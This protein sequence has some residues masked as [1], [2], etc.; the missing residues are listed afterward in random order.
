MNRVKICFQINF[1]VLVLTG[2]S[3]GSCQ[4]PKQWSGKWFQS[5]VIS[6][7]QINSTY[8]ETKGECYEE[9]GEKVVVYDRSENCYRCMAIHVK[10]PSVLQYK[11]TF[12]EPSSQDICYDISGD[13]PL[14]SMFRKIP[15]A[16]PIPCPFKSA[17]F[18]FQYNKGSEEC[19][20]PPSKAESC[21]DDSRLVL[22]YQACPDVPGT[23]SNVEE[24]ICLAVWKEGSTRYLV[25]KISQWNRRSLNT[26]EDQ[27]RCF[28]Y[29]RV[30][31]RDGE[32]IYN[33]AQSGDASCNGIT[34]ALEGSKTMKLRTVDNHHNRCKF[35]TWITDHHTWLSLDH[36]KT[37][38][39]SQ[40]NAT[41]KIVD[42]DPKLLTP[43]R[44]RHDN[45]A[46]QFAFQTLGFE[47]QEQRKT[48]AEMR[49][50]CH[51]ILQSVEQR[52]VQIVAHITHGCDSGYICMVFHKRDS[53][54]IEIQ[55]SGHETGYEENADDAC[56]NFD[57]INTPYTTLITTTLHP[58]NCPHL[59]RYTLEP[60]PG[61][62]TTEERRKKRQ[63]PSTQST[64]NSNSNS[65]P[66]PNF[67]P[68]QKQSI[69]LDPSLN[70]PQHL[71]P[72]C[73]S[74]DFE[75]LAVGCG[76]SQEVMEFRTPCIQQPIAGFTCHGSWEENNTFFVITSPLTRRA[77]DSM[78]Y[79]F[80]YTFSG[81]SRNGGGGMMTVADMNMG[82]GR[83]GGGNG[84]GNGGIGG[85]YGSGP[86]N[87]AHVLMI[88][89]LSGNCN[90]DVIPGVKGTWA[91]NFTSNGTC[92]E[93]Q[94]RSNGVSLLLTAATILEIIVA[95]WAALVI[96]R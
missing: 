86:G 77:T 90:R 49:V 28:I 22:K 12:C 51:S 4:F 85:A 37:Y 75:A 95:S 87:G 16:K 58:Q 60:T 70:H 80:V 96:V 65:N 43:S 79:C 9:Q 21:T 89:G 42:E 34:N 45:Y 94:L 30:I 74:N 31:G 56:K 83:G 63:Q 62:S 76:G 26:D 32:V 91:F 78:R 33:I 23:E 66:N 35:P 52:K 2:I 14:Y 92:A 69:S 1:I 73:I 15:E 57:P 39:F 50:V 81:G 67:N 46:A 40:R 88:S 8:I 64:P 25:G 44:Q 29:Q 54:V 6:H 27:F 84:G 48:N 17:P 7:I 38:K 24:L 18:T 13:A 11:E 93:N 53:G 5:G 41:L 82:F 20:N 36:K 72:E 71:P 19:T 61:S 10:H 59:G 68:N 3:E 55:Q 47:S